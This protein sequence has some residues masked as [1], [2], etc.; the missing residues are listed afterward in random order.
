MKV[1]GLIFALFLIIN[2]CW[3]DQSAFLVRDFRGFGIIKTQPEGIRDQIDHTI[4]R[5]WKQN[6]DKSCLYSFKTRYR[7][8]WL[9]DGE[10]IY[11]GNSFLLGN[12]VF[13]NR[14]QISDEKKVTVYTIF[15]MVYKIEQNQNFFASLAER[16]KKTDPKLRILSAAL[17]T[18]A[19]VYLLPYSSFEKYQD[20]DTSKD[21][22]KF[23]K[24]TQLGIYISIIPA[25]WTGYELL[26]WIF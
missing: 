9:S 12:R 19:A 25:V 15:N 6:L 14:D 4:Y 20:T 2:L 3:A 23:R 8:N 7:H 13:S 18:A 10:V 17:T 5:Y 22:V 16:W 24:S 26:N 21:A 11:S 1:T